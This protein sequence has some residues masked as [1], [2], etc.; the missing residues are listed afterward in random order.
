MRFA[1]LGGGSK[2][3]ASVVQSGGQTLLI[4]AGLSAK[5]LALRLELLGLA[6]NALDAILL[7][8]EHGDHTRGLDVF[9]KK[10]PVPVIANRLTARV[11]QEKMKHQAEWTC[12]ESGQTFPW[13]DF[14]IETFALPHDA[15]EPVGY[16]ISRAEKTVA[17]ATDLGHVTTSVQRALLKAHGLVLEANYDWSL[18]ESDTKRPFATKQ[19]IS[20]RHGHLSNEQVTDLLRDLCAPDLPQIQLQSLV[21][22]H[23][24]SDCNTPETAT[25]QARTVTPDHIQIHCAG[26]D[27]PTAWHTVTAPPQPGADALLGELF[28]WNQ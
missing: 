7:T 5:Q 1:V 4:D 17:V 24:S 27:E 25:Q 13:R 14:S 22:T 28:A 8:H 12:F 20:S 6:P 23:L 10:W 18:L 16:L 21:L 19:R 11:V 15:V 26:Q 3:N 2:G 9:L